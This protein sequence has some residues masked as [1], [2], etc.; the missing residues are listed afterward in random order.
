MG[1][2]RDTR[3]SRDPL[4]LTCQRRIR[5]WPS[6]CSPSPLHQLTGAIRSNEKSHPI[7]IIGSTICEN[8]ER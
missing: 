2:F 1:D 6:T 8:F 3:V 4:D 7:P 5:S